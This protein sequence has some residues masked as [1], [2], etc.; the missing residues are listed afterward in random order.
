MY[1]GIGQ[2]WVNLKNKPRMIIFNAK[3]HLIFLSIIYLATSLINF[4]I[5]PTAHVKST[6]YLSN[7]RNIIIGSLNKKAL[8]Q[9]LSFHIYFL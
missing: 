4:W 7:T 9:I 2:K 1:R 5:I 3:F 8:H 6:F